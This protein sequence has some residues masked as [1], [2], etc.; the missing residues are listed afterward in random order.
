MSSSQGPRKG[1][2]ENIDAADAPPDFEALAAPVLALKKGASMN[3]VYAAITAVCDALDGAALPTAHAVRD[4][5]CRHLRTVVGLQSPASLFDSLL[6]DKRPQDERPNQV[7]ELIALAHER[8]D[9][10]H[11][12]DGRAFAD[13]R[14][15]THRE[16]H[17]LRARSFARFLRS[18]YFEKVEKGVSEQA[19][20]DAVATLEGFAFRDGSVRETC[21]RFG[22]D[23]TSGKVYLDLGDALWRAIEID[24]GGWRLVADVPVRFLRPA[25]LRPLPDPPLRPAGAQ[26]RLDSEDWR[27]FLHIDE[28]DRPVVLAWLVAALLVRGP[29]VTLVLLGEQ[30]SG[31]S[32][33]A[34]LLRIL[35]DP[36]KAPLRSTPR[37]ER[38]IVI[39]AGNGGVVAFDNVSYISD[40]LADAMCRLSTGAGFS[41]RAL[42]TNDEEYLFEGRRPQLL[43]GITN[44]IARD[45]L[46]DRSAVLSIPLLKSPEPEEDFWAALEGARPCL[47]ADLLDLASATL[48][49]LP[50]AK[51]VLAGERSP[52]MADFTQVGVAADI[53]LGGTGY[54]FLERYREIL[55]GQAGEVLT[56]DPVGAAI[57]EFLAPGDEWRGT[58]A[59]LLDALGRD[60]ATQRRLPKTPRGLTAG[61]DR[62]KPALRRVGISFERSGRGDERKIELRR[63]GRQAA[64]DGRRA[65]AEAATRT[66]APPTRPAS[67]EVHGNGTA[68]VGTHGAAPPQQ[69]GTE[70]SG[71]SGPSEAA[72]SAAPP[73]DGRGAAPGLER[74]GTVGGAAASDST[75]R[76]PAGT[77]GSGHG[78]KYVL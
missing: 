18:A 39:A 33:T 29:F 43:N 41:T 30:G 67:R 74:N 22:K 61:L 32:S 65:A 60:E 57:L 20:S 34:R 50:E 3:E 75:S 55:R 27:R 1:W 35:I 7:E 36:A 73:P 69:A 63:V 58:A 48:A 56:D 26:P 71:Q 54:G 24:D 76:A 42:Y 12:G 19:V 2:R 52:R 9:L 8:C 14:T 11:D 45:D 77:G 64:A 37:E 70:P 16:T 78:R 66:G 53:S 23:A 40:L 44:F 5:A 17:P 25:G 62:L 46:A 38:D 28:A 6:R 15:E 13:V 4:L 68:G 47:L 21:V 51:A 59:G 49:R 31:K 72:S 10:F